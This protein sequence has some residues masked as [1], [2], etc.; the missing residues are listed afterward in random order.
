MGL[1]AIVGDLWH[2]FVSSIEHRHSTRAFGHNSYACAHMDELIEPWSQGTDKEA[3][4]ELETPDPVQ[5]EF[6]HSFLGKPRVEAVREYRD[7]WAEHVH[8]DFAK[9]TSVLE[10]LEEKAMQVFVPE[11]WEGIK[12]LEP[13]K[14][15]FKDDLPD[16]I[17]PK[18]RYINPRL[19]EA[20]E[21]E[22]KRLRGYFYEESRSPWAS[23]LVM[24]PKATYPFIRF[25][26]DYVTINRYIATGHFFIPNV[27]HELEKI[28]NYP[29]YL[30]IDLTNAFHQIRLDPDTAEKLS[31][32]TP[33]GQFQPRFM[34]EGIG[35]GSGVLQETVKKI[36]GD[37]G[38]W[39]IL[40]FDNALILAEDYTDAYVKLE[41]FID[42]SIQFNVKLKF[43]KTWLGFTE[44]KFFGYMCRHKSYG[45]TDDRKK[46]ILDIPFPDSGNKI[47]KVR[48]MLGCGVFFSPFIKN[49]SDLVSHIPDM[50][51][52]TFNWDEAMWKYDY[53]ALWES[54][55][56]GLQQ[57]C[58]LFY[59]D[60]SLEWIL[61]TDASDFGVGGML[62]QLYVREDGTV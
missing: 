3:P 31:V 45:L 58:E 53:R 23:C 32:Q 14:I 7:L 16:R 9:C 15:N 62:I 47:K 6:A 35:P 20:A 24:A 34:P 42:R 48:M 55:K 52:T 27:R 21:K 36:Y 38:D 12:G 1:P 39:C 40:L 51:K 30:D 37:F 54:F 60:Y 43:S 28:I 26:G 5:F 13:L 18:T 29:I 2:F 8:P 17:K 41:M 46:A 19:Y 49:Y 11:T 25:C 22:F 4:E 61:R 56:L 50:T 59:P 10:L 33:W 57:S 44:V